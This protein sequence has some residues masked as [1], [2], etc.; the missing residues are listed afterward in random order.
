M[1][2]IVTKKQIFECRLTGKPIIL[3]RRNV[4]GKMIDEARL[5]FWQT[6]VLRLIKPEFFEHNTSHRGLFAKAEYTHP[7]TIIDHDGLVYQPEGHRFSMSYNV[8][9]WLISRSP[10]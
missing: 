2:Q 8:Y 9:N 4:T 6:G 5:L 7:I 10:T 3:D 1:K